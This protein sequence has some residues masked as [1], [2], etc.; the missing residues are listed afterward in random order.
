MV[1]VAAPFPGTLAPLA[2]G[3]RAPAFAVGGQPPAST[4]VLDDVTLVDGTGAAAVT[5]ARLV[6][7]GGW[8]RARRSHGRRA[9]AGRRRADRSRRPNVMPGL[10]DVHFHIEGDPRLALRQLANG[11]TSFR[12]PGPW[13]DKFDPLKAIMRSDI[14][15]ARACRSPV[16]T[17]TVNIRPIRS[18][19]PSRAIP[20][21]PGAPPNATSPKAPRP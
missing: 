2:A 19:P 3:L 7:A 1:V 12:D 9:R 10:V 11:V 15:P 6:I 4:T 16:R 21:K 20:K 13:I 5:G 8:I 14:F 17:S 18:M